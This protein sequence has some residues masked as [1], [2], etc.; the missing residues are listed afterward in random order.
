[1][2]LVGCGAEK[3]AQTERPPHSGPPKISSRLNTETPGIRPGFFRFSLRRSV[4]VPRSSPIKSIIHADQDSGRFCVGVEETTSHTD[5]GAEYIYD[6]STRNPCSCL[7]GT[8]TSSARTSIQRRH[9]LSNLFWSCCPRRQSQCQQ[10]L[11]LFWR[12]PR[13]RRPDRR[14]TRPAP[15]HSRGGLS[16][17]RTN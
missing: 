7:P 9:L 11:R 3:I 14:L 5:S 6:R 12:W 8:P 16:G 17:C 2:K 4:L 13:L 10:K 15:P 1:M